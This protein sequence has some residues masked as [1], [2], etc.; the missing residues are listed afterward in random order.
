MTGSMSSEGSKTKPIA[1]KAPLFVSSTTLYEVLNLSI[2][3]IESQVIIS[4]LPV[5]N[6][7]RSK[8]STFDSKISRDIFLK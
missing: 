5:S 8:S 6:S 4:T 1:L 7:S 2:S 3:I